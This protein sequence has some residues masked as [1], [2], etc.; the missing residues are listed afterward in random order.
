MILRFVIAGV[1]IVVLQGCASKA[2]IPIDGT[3]RV[4]VVKSD[5]PSNYKMIAPITA[6]DGSGCGAFGSVGSYNNAVMLIKNIAYQM[7]GDYV[8]IYTMEAPYFRP[9]CRVNTYTISGTLYKSRPQPQR[10]D[11]AQKHSENTG[12]SKLRELKSLLDDGI[13]TQSDF[14]NQKKKILNK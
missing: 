6:T 1:M 7:G 14:D 13:I 12:L 11:V 10:T 9:G 4:K 5:P 8:Q 2:V 3:D